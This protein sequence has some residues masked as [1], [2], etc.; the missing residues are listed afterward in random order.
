MI[1]SSTLLVDVFVD[2]SRMHRQPHAFEPLRCASH[3]RGGEHVVRGGMR[4]GARDGHGG[5]HQPEPGSRCAAPERLR[6]SRLENS[7]AGWISCT[8]SQCSASGKMRG[9][10]AFGD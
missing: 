1:E 5:L 6:L 8:E 3:A 2:W 4:T 7:R 10:L 9:T